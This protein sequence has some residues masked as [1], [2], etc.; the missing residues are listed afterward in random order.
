[1]K[2]FFVFLLRFSLHII[3]HFHEIP[4]ESFNMKLI[5]KQKGPRQEGRIHDLGTL[6]IIILVTGDSSA[7]VPAV[8]T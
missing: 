1:M 3:E 5:C 7:G 4:Q 6:N 2:T 8:E